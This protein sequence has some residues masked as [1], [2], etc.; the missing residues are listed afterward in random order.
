[1]DSFEK[2]PDKLPQG[3]GSLLAERYR[4][5]APPQVELGPKTKQARDAIMEKMAC[6]AYGTFPRRCPLCGQDRPRGLSQTDRWGFP[7]QTAICRVCGFVY[8]TPCLDESSYQDFYGC[9][10]RDLYNSPDEDLDR[11][12]QKEANTGRS[13]I[14]LLK[15]LGYHAQLP[16]GSLVM[17][18]GTGAGGML[19]PWMKA[20][21]KILGLDWGSKYVEY[22]RTHG[23]DL[24][25]SSLG[26]FTPPEP[27][28][29]V[30]YNQVLEHIVDPGAELELLRKIIHPQGLVLVTVPGVKNVHRFFKYK[31][32][33]LHYLEIAHVN[34]FSRRTLEALAQKTGFSMGYG[35]EEIIALLTPGPRAACDS[36]GES[37]EY[38]EV[39]A[40]LFRIERFRRLVRLVCEYHR[41]SK[42]I[43][44][45]L[46]ALIKGGPLEGLARTMYRRLRY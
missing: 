45:R 22:G 8:T 17:D 43:Q 9:E 6:R 11:F 12:F 14:N 38:Q 7:H 40:Y 29:L 42:A 28:R 34:Y 41:L 44:D 25:V 27:P 16:P 10:Y 5:P 4:Y 30:I 1:M 3:P 46:A 36:P 2:A 37:Q 39:M 31:G 21:F 24:H 13:F 15:D 32:C 35:N 18:V 20:G 33:F 26:D 23:L 19:L